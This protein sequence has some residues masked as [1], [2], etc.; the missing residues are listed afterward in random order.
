[1]VVLIVPGIGSIGWGSLWTWADDGTIIWEEIN[2]TC[3]C[4]TALS[5]VWFTVLGLRPCCYQP[6]FACRITLSRVKNLCSFLWDSFPS[7]LCWCYCCSVRGLHILFVLGCDAHT[8]SC[9]ACWGSY[10]QISVLAR[11]HFQWQG[12]QITELPGLCS[13]CVWALRAE[14]RPEGVSATGSSLD[15]L[16][17]CFERFWHFTNVQ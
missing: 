7:L 14:I 4:Q 8:S 15:P 17:Q 3:L 5:A 13:L 6:L 1:M 9:G 11:N 12:S 2:C 16:R 10:P